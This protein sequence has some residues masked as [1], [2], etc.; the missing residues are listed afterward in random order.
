MCVHVCLHMSRGQRTALDDLPSVTFLFIPL[1]KGHSLNLKLIHFLDKLVSVIP[2]DFLDPVLPQRGITDVS[3]A[4]LSCWRT[5]HSRW[6]FC[7]SFSSVG[8]PSSN[9][10]LIV[11]TQLSLSHLV[12]KLP[13]VIRLS[14][15]LS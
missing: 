1:R 8:M 13:T 3:R 4:H 5:Q 9:S 11:E 15:H 6:P 12:I 14:C 10:F 7:L 2:S